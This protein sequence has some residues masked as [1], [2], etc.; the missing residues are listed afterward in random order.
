[1]KSYLGTLK[2]L[3][4]ASLA[5]LAVIVAILQSKTDEPSNSKIL[6]QVKTGL[7][8]EKL[9]TSD[10]KFNLWWVSDDGFSIANDDSLSV[11][12][13]YFNC[14]ADNNTDQR[15]FWTENAIQQSKTVDV[16]M[17]QAGFKV[18]ELNSSDSLED[19]QFVD[20]VRAYERGKTKAA[21]VVN[22]D[23]WSVGSVDSSLYYST[24]FSITDDFDVNY[25]AQSPYLI[26]LD[27]KDVVIHVSNAVD[28]WASINVNYRRSG[29]YVI[30]EKV[31]GKW[32]E[33]FAGQD[34][35]SCTLRN[36]LQIPLELAPDCAP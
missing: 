33:K 34:I 2:M 20:Y 28:N 25:E 18:N 21:L 24:S 31:D 14:E 5:T 9:Q 17:Q 13:K 15:K 12:T 10:A 36:D 29:H 4:L 16:I 8:S 23:C 3:A 32:L 22:A 6:E 35:I 30:A 11:E 27:L 19:L 1:M 26:D 7:A